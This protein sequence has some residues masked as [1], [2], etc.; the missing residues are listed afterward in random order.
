M[1]IVSTFAIPLDEKARIKREKSGEIIDIKSF[2][3]IFFKKVAGF[4]IVCNFA[5]PN[6]RKR[7]RKTLEREKREFFELLEQTKISN[8]AVLYVNMILRVHLENIFKFFITMESLIL[9]QDE[10]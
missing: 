9:A 7:K 6:E 8:N 2:E 3:K 4:K 5:A 10:R 1:K